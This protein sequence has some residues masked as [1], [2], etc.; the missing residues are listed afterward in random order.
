[1]SR[2]RPKVL[3]QDQ[4]KTFYPKTSRVY[5]V[6]SSNQ[7]REYGYI[8]HTVMHLVNHYQNRTK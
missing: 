5:H 3:A 8:M 1:M 7:S 4:G 6:A 2:P